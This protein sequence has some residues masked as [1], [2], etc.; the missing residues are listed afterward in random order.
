MIIY[1][2]DVEAS[3]VRMMEII[4]KF[5]YYAGYK[6]N[7]SKT[8]ILSFNHIPSIE[9][10]N[11]YGVKWDLKQM[12]YLGVHITKN[13]SNLYKAN[14]NYIN[15]NIRKDIERWSTYSMDFSSKINTVKMNI[16]PWLLYLFQ[17]LP[18]EIPPK[19]FIEWDKLVSRF[20]WRG[21]KARIKYTTL[22]LPKNRGGMALRNFKVYFHA[23][24]LRPLVYWCDENYVARWKDV[25]TCIP[26][27][28]IQTLLGEN[29]IPGY[30]RNLID[31]ITIFTL[32]TWFTLTRQL[33]LK[34]E[35]KILKWVA[36]D[37]E[38]RPGLH[39]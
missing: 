36:L 26:G 19:Q 1:L 38:F 25:E 2:T 28:H 7:L 29:T 5:N 10:K 4:E 23:A 30:I 13:I 3:F 21:R 6:L 27:Y 9:I 35:Q 18:I 32:E 14:Y 12:K 15:Q 8:Q 39:D 34:K 22:Q 11:K 16:L 33:K 31:P 37:S 20:I 24:Q 17:S